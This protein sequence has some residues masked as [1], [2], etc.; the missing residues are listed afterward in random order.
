[1]INRLKRDSFLTNVITLISGTAISQGILFAATPF[2]TRLY[3]PEDFGYFSL[4]AA[5][6][7]VI[8]SVA[9]LKYESAIML[10][11]E[12]KD[13]QAILFLS[14]ITTFIT[15]GFVFIIILLF[16]NFIILYITDKVSKFLWIVPLGVL[17]S[18]LYQVFISY[19]S[20]KK[21]FSSVAA[22]RITQSGAAVGVQLS[23]KG[24]NVFSQGLIWGKLLGD[25]FALIL[26]LFKHI[27]EQTV[28]LNEISK[29]NILFNASK[30]K[31]FPKYQSIAQFLSSLS[32]NIPFFLLST[33]YNPEIAG[34]YMLTSRVLSVPAALISRSTRDVYYQKASEIFAKGESI[35]DLFIKT[36][37]G[38]AKIGIIPFIIVGI[39]AQWIF[40][41]FLGPDWITSGIY[42]QIIIVWSFIGFVNPPSTMTIYVMGLQKF[43]LKY[44]SLSV[45]FRIL[46]I[47]VSFLIFNNHFITMGFYSLTGIIFNIILVTYCFK[48]VKNYKYEHRSN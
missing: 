19:S 6:V 20:R 40:S 26:L 3:T 7:A 4:Y 29:K 1:M 12:E 24:L 10:P 18:G 5:I 16:K 35:K 39:F 9:S 22:S 38:L 2:L 30:Y 15:A 13:A 27:R 14:V 44:E 46:S 42:A 34:F 37:A 41:V 43:S 47:Y 32:Q 28:Q 33:L 23:N 45:V 25:F 36:T 17:I 8:S 48:K 11:K 31:N 21:Y